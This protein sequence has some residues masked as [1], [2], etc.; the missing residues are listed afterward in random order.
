VLLLHR[1]E[2]GPSPSRPPRRAV[3]VP[4]GLI[5]WIAVFGW[6]LGLATVLGGFGGYLVIVAAFV[7]ACLRIER[8][9]ARQN[10]S[11]L[12]DYRQ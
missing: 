10:W 12:R 7:V 4:F 11:G 6:L 5:A 2:P 1:E 3:A 8:W 9:A